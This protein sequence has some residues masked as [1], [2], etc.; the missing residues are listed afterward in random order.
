M[1]IRKRLIA[2]DG[3]WITNGNRYW[4]RITIDI[5]AD[6]SSFHEIT[7]EEYEEIRKREEERAEETI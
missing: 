3:K 1:K 2:E 7:E 4:K 5:G 6:E